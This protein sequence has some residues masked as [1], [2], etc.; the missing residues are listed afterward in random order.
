[1]SPNSCFFHKTVHSSHMD[2]MTLKA[3]YDTLWEASI[4]ELI[5]Y[6]LFAFVFF[7]L[8]RILLNA[9]VNLLKFEIYSRKVMG[10]AVLAYFFFKWK[11]LVEFVEINFPIE[12]SFLVFASFVLLMYLF[13][14]RFI[15]QMFIT[16]ILTM[17]IV[18]W[19]RVDTESKRG[20][21]FKNLHHYRLSLKE[22]WGFRWN[23]LRDTMDY[24]NA[25]ML[26]LVASGILVVESLN[27]NIQIGL[28]V[29]V[30]CFFFL[31]YGWKHERLSWVHHLNQRSEYTAI[32]YKAEKYRD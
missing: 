22:L 23:S 14:Y 5:V 16:P 11:T 9:E 15:L 31:Y 24:V 25:M 6:Y 7:R 18:L 13:M 26:N 3:L 30:Y 4:V 21:G 8:I 2:E 29:A 32:I 20:L 17:L 28:I 10:G 27:I 19:N 1:M 12:Y